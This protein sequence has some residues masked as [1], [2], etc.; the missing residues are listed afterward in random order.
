MKKL[1]V[2]C[3]RDWLNP[4]SGAVERYVYEVFSRIAGV[5]H[6]VAWVCHDS[7]FRGFRKDKRPEIENLDGI[8]LVRVRVP[9]SYRMMV[10][11]FL[12]RLSATAKAP[13]KFDVAVDCITG[14]PL[15]IADYTDIPVVPLVFSL[16]RR[17][18][19]SAAPPGPVIAATDR[20]AS[21]L[22]RA[23]VPGKEIVRAPYG[24]DTALC[25]P[26]QEERDPSHFVALDRRPRLLLRALRLL[27]KDGLATS[28]DLVGSRS[29]CRD[30]GVTHHRRIDEAHRLALY[31]KASFAYC[32][33][34]AE[35]QALALGACGVPVVSP[36]TLD[37]NEFVKN[38]ETGLLFPP[39]NKAQL[40]DRLRRLAKDEVL[41]GRLGRRAL[42]HAQSATWDQTTSLVLATIENL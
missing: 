20:A 38:G 14:H 3:Y 40:A 9:L 18:R 2:F 15:P 34:G 10:R 27:R 26:V 17:A 4:K 6:Y 35:W 8:Q 31:R 24:V 5:G 32:G 41:R 13:G 21:R 42:A 19:V 12:S 16:S 7:P 30:E 1:L 23:G 29:P 39:G 28:V 36:A 11:L 33:A 25:A 22:R 37:G